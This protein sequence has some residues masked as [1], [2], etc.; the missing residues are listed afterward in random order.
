MRQGEN[1]GGPR[2]VYTHSECLS[3]SLSAIEAIKPP[4]FHLDSSTSIQLDIDTVAP[5]DC[6]GFPYT[7]HWQL[8]SVENNQ[9]DQ[10]F[11]LQLGQ[12]GNSNDSIE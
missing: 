10:E 9:V 4:Y 3:Q 1:L 2:R 11:G 7:E 5:S 12:T 8:N 6:A